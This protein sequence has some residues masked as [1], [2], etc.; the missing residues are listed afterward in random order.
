MYGF[1]A[2]HDRKVQENVVFSWTLLRFIC[3]AKGAEKPAVSLNPRYPFV[4]YIKNPATRA[5]NT[6]RSHRASTRSSTG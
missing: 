2:S 6:T 1:G 3:G 4:S 5:G